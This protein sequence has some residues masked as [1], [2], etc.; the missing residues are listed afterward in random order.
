LVI[1]V[2]SLQEKVLQFDLNAPAN[3]ALVEGVDDV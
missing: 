1:E 2:H 3:S